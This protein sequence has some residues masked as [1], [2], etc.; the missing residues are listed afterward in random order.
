MIEH[1]VFHP[2]AATFRTT[3]EVQVLSKCFRC[4]FFSEM[5]APLFAVP[6]KAKQLDHLPMIQTYSNNTAKDL[7]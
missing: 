4:L 1:V 3:G 5:L 7:S 2:Q 6:P